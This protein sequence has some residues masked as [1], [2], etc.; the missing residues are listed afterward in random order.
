MK[1]L[2]Y[3]L[4]LL[5]VITTVACETE[6]EEIIAANKRTISGFLYKNCNKEPYANR[7]YKFEAVSFGSNLSL[8]TETIYK[9]TAT[10]DDNGYFNFTYSGCGDKLVVTE[11]NGLLAFELWGCYDSYKNYTNVWYNQP[12]S[13]HY[14]KILTDSSYSDSDSLYIGAR[15]QSKTAYTN[16]IGPFQNE[17]VYLLDSIRFLLYGGGGYLPVRETDTA[18]SK[19]IWGLGY[20][21]YNSVFA[22]GYGREKNI[23]DVRLSVCGIGDT[24]VIDLRGYR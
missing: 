14:L 13:S 8:K 3:F 21:D 12:K 6:D 17:D 7:T 18:D 19:I 9:G 5:I 20:K 10:T 2:K 11:I 1:N 24:A 22:N 4:A 16:Y 23:I 15:G